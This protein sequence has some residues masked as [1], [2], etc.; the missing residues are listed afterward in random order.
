MFYYRCKRSQNSESENKSYKEKDALRLS[1]SVWVE[2]LGL[3][4][5]ILLMDVLPLETTIN[6][7]LRKNCSVYN[8]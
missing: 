2:A 8:Y 5:K 1:V 6:H 7:C 3:S 4:D